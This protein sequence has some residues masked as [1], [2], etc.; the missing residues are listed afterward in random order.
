[1]A[2]EARKQMLAVRIAR[3][4]LALA[5]I[6]NYYT[7]PQL[8]MSAAQRK[9]ARTEGKKAA[10][11]TVENVDLELVLANVMLNLP[12]TQKGYNV[13]VRKFLAY[14]NQTT[15]MPIHKE[16]LTDRLMGGFIFAPGV[17]EDHAQ[18]FL[19]G[20]SAS[21]GT[22]LVRFELPEIYTSPHLYPVCKKVIKVNLLLFNTHMTALT[23]AIYPAGLAQR[24]QADAVGQDEGQGIQ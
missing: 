24:Q 21:L 11:Q 20:T 17:Q 19:K 7:R 14:M 8:Q 18:H 6:F 22:E 3:L 15:L 1:L 12:K 10:M 5:F 4:I 9:K 16:W 23:V 2:E 13:Y